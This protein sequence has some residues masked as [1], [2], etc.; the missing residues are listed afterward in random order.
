MTSFSFR[1]DRP[2][3]LVMTGKFVAPT[4]EWRHMHRMLH[5]FELFIQTRGTL[6]IAKD[7][8]RHIL[9]E[10][11]FLLMP[12]GAEQAGYRESDCSFYWLHFAVQ[13][14]YQLED[15]DPGYEPGKVWIPEKGTL[16]SQDK[17]IV[18]LKQ[19]QDSVRSY[20]EQTLNN[21]L[22][23]GILCELYNQLYFIQNQ[24]GKKLKQQQ[25]YNDLV[26]YIK[27]NRQESLKVSQLAEHFGYNAKYLSSLFSEIAGVPLK[28]FMLQEKMDAA[29]SLLA[30]TNQ[31]IKEI[32]QQ[33]GYLDSH[34]FMHSFKR[35]TGLTP[36]DYRNAYANRLL[37]YR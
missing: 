33:L 18:L 5:E 13:D 22:T 8:E 27:W 35:M 24:S 31:S 12:P 7:N 23:T 34:Q 11:D 32:S 28:Q 3:T 19:L 9:N 29:K 21:Y 17:L 37:F 20:R 30:D 36:T 2:V 25:L 14:G 4:P 26:D 1:V 10:G 16:R 15:N 6:Y